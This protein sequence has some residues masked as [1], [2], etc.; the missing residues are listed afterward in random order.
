MRMKW[1]F[2][3]L[4]IGIIAV[5]AG[6]EPVM[7]LDP[8][9]PQA[10]TISNVI[11]ISIATMAIVVIVVF[12]YVGIHRS[13]ISCFET[14]AQIMNPRISKVIRLLNAIIVGIPVHNH[15]FPFNCHCQIHL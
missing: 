12:G 7:V 8:K 6:C 13:K 2:L 10:E 15:H 11:W 1:T 9:G 14:R 4:V 5:L 3:S